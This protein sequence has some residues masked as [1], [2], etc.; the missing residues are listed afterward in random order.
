[1]SDSGF[2]VVHVS[3]KAVI[4][5]IGAVSTCNTK[6]E[7]MATGKSDLLPGTFRHGKILNRERFIAAVKSSLSAAEIMGNL[8]IRSVIVC[9]SSPDLICKNSGGQIFLHGKNNHAINNADMAALLQ[10]AKAL[11]IPGDA[12]LTEFLLQAIWVDNHSYV[13]EDVIG[14]RGV[15]RLKASYHLMAIPNRLHQELVDIFREWN[16]FIENFIFESMAG[17][18]YAL[19]ESEKQKGVLYIN[20]GESVTN[21]CLYVNNSI[22][23]SGCLDIGGDDIN[24]EL[25]QRLENGFCLPKYEV[26]RLKRDYAKLVTNH[27]DKSR[28]ID[29][30]YTQEDLSGRPKE[31]KSCGVINEY[32][33]CQALIDAYDILF[34]RLLQ[35]IAQKGLL[36][37]FSAG[38]VLAGG[39]S[40]AKDIVPYL[41]NKID[42][43]PVQ[44]VNQNDRLGLH[45]SCQYTDYEG[46]IRQALVRQEYQMAL[47]SMLCYANTM[48]AYNRRVH[49]VDDDN[50]SLLGKV[51]QLFGN[52]AKQVKNIL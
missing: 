4:T 6:V 11:A 17:A 36:G 50:K 45:S 43:L 40:Q 47:G 38:V 49:L 8:R 25:V 41:R 35:E 7:L 20:I 34:D 26:E 2:V 21:Y 3:T 27:H 51:G 9:L 29:V 5:C 16:I 13:L 39:G 23:A 14:V 42:F 28:F 31:H 37:G 10:N 32:L 1:M 48:M 15:E 12:Y 33:L 30:Y 46:Q 19:M 52:F 44:L 24:N 18:E 22:L